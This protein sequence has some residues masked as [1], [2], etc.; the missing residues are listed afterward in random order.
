MILCG[1]KAVFFCCIYSESN[2][3]RR[4]LNEQMINSFF[5]IICTYSKNNFD[6]EISFRKDMVNIYL[7]S[8]SAANTVLPSFKQHKE[9]IRKPSKS[10]LLSFNSRSISF[11]IYF[12][13]SNHFFYHL[14]LQTWQNCLFDHRILICDPSLEKMMQH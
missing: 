3:G 14:N 1:N 11:K 8:V 12:D 9:R 6:F 10:F 2:N 13:Y 4:F 7:L 5:K